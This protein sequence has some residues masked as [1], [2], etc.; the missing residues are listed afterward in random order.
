MANSFC[1]CSAVV[2][3]FLAEPLRARSDVEGASIAK[4]TG[5][6][7]CE[8]IWFWRQRIHA[9]LSASPPVRT[10]RERLIR[11]CKEGDGESKTCSLRSSSGNLV[12]ANGVFPVKNWISF[13]WLTT[14]KALKKIVLRMC[15]WLGRAFQK[16][17]NI[18]K[19]S[20]PAPIESTH[21]E[22]KSRSDSSFSS[23]L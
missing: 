23:F 13:V 1:Y 16:K 6:H 12:T 9:G 15:F 2:C 22:D 20:I 5:N 17:K 10:G 18:K 19:C 21:G 8:K 3:R 4:E 11:F 14:K 7:R